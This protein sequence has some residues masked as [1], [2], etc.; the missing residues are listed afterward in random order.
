MPQVKAT[1]A[2]VSWWLPAPTLVKL[3]TRGHFPSAPR[4]SCSSELSD[5]V[6]AKEL[7]ASGYGDEINAENAAAGDEEGE[8][9]GWS[10]EE[11][12]AISAL[13]ERPMRQ[14]PLKLPNPVRQRA[15]PLPLPHKTRLPVAPAPKQHVRL[16]ARAALS[17]RTSFSDQVRKNPE[18]LL[19]IAREIA[20]L[21]PEHGVSTVLD[22]WVRF[23]RKG[24]LLLTIRELGHMGLPERALQTL[25]WAQRQK[26]VPLFPDDRVLASTIEVLA[27]FGQLKVESAL[28]Q[29]VP[30]V[31]AVAFLKPWPAGSSEQGK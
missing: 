28:E 13:F 3:R 7:E 30:T 16:A 24:S 9:L 21:P 19:G 18:F 5:R 25:C 23:L 27:C 12:D 14:K 31:R 1:P 10:K 2:L 15:F 6:S 20:A 29:C 26:A 4:I 8:Y 17:S 11:I 22:R